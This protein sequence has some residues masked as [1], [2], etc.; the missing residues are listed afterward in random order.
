MYRSIDIIFVP[1]GAEHR[2]VCQG[3]SRINRTPLIVP[4]PVG[5][6]AVARF[7]QSWRWPERSGSSPGWAILIM[8]L[9][10]SLSTQYSIGT[11]VLY[12]SCRLV[13]DRAPQ[14]ACDQ[15]L[16][17]QL[18]HMLKSSTPELVDALTSDRLIWSAQE[19]QQLGQQ[20]G[21][22]VVDMEGYALLKPLNAAHAAVAML[23]VVSDGCQDDL[24][25]LT[26][27]IDGQGQLRS[28]PMALGM[29]RHPIAAGRLIQGSLRGLGVLRTLSA[30]VV[31]AGL[32]SE[33]PNQ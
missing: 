10:G 25:D 4:I 15:D 2:A 19:K 5:P 29:L 11:P 1:Q 20:T 13:D 28:W 22:A 18:Q 23:R 33:T 30:Q 9:C 16:T 21:A 32:N 7:L 24:P 8:G 14:T 26:A 12:R 6:E 27:A 17:Q 3:L 31:V